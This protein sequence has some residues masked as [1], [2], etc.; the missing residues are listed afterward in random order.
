MEW[1]EKIR[2]ALGSPLLDAIEVNAA[3]EFPDETRLNFV[4]TLLGVP[5]APPYPDVRYTTPTPISEM[6]RYY[7]WDDVR[8]F[9]Q[10]FQKRVY[11]TDKTDLSINGWV[12]WI[13]ER[14]DIIARNYIDSEKDEDSESINLQLQV[15][16]IGGQHSMYRRL[17]KDNPS[18][19]SHSWR[20]E[21][22]AFVV[23]DG[24]YDPS[25]AN[26]LQT[27]TDW[28]LKNDECAKEGGVF[29]NKDRRMLWGSYGRKDDKDGGASLD[30]VWDKYYDSKEKYDRLVN[31]KRKVDPD[32]IFTANTFGVDAI[33]APKE[34]Q[35]MILSHGY[36]L[37]QNGSLSKDSS[38]SISFSSNVDDATLCGTITKTSHTKSS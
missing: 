25:K 21:S 34:K 26:A 33:N 10:P 15:A 23:L 29:C 6:V 13:S 24:F 16:P 38:K 19:D 11:L 7:I 36:E 8:E 2:E 27:V 14:V 18:H 4:K 3:E 37:R 5:N 12:Q 9:P 31:I 32:Y 30:L 28:M 35:S 22:T 1:F 20:N 17:A